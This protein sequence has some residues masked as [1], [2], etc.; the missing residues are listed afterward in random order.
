MTG[1]IG[2]IRDQRPCTSVLMGMM[3]ET[4][5]V[6]HMKAH[7]VMGAACFTRVIFETSFS[8]HELATGARET[9]WLYLALV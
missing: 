4:S 9:N 2:C 8:L 5:T 6:K 3:D 1:H 7:L